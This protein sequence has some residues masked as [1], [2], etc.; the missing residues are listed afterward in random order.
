MFLCLIKLL[1]S[2]DTEGKK[3]CIFMYL[4]IG[5]FFENLYCIAQNFN[6]GRPHTAYFRIFVCLCLKKRN[7]D[8]RK[9]RGRI[10]QRTYFSKQFS[11]LSLGHNYIKYILVGQRIDLRQR[12]CI[13][14]SLE[15]NIKLPEAQQSEVS[16]PFRSRPPQQTTCPDS[17]QTQFC[18]CIKYFF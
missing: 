5:Y 16:R 17:Q 7:S 14:F 1:Y 12:N 15:I 8:K 6:R 11:Q 2:C 4:A 3:H 10:K 9:I 13:R 18:D